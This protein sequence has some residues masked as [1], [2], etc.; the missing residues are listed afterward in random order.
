MSES[1]KRIVVEVLAGQAAQLRLFDLGS[2][3]PPS[4]ENKAW[5]CAKRRFYWGCSSTSKPEVELLLWY[6]EGRLDSLSLHANGTVGRVVEVCATY[7]ELKKALANELG[8]PLRSQVGPCE[9]DDGSV[10]RPSCTAWRTPRGTV[11]VSLDRV[12]DDMKLGHLDLKLAPDQREAC[13]EPG[14]D[15]VMDELKTSP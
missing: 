7:L 13:P 9:D 14:P 4:P 3:E 10:Y 5:S 11:S 12:V 6:Y 2:A 8:P 1:D 15:P